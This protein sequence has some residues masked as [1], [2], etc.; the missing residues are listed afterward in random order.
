MSGVEAEPRVLCRDDGAVRTLSLSNPRKRNALT[1]ALLDELVRLL[2]SEAPGPRQPVRAVILQG[3]PA[4][5]AFSSGFDI[6]AIDAEEREKGLDPIR[7]AAEAIEGCPVPVI[8]AIDGA[9]FGGG[10]E[11]A[12][13]CH[14]R[15]ASSGVK[16]SMPPAKLGV[17]YSSTGLLRFLRALG[18]SQ[19]TRLFLTGEVV[20]ADEAARIGLV[21][22]R[23]DEGRA[24]E[25]ARE[26]A[27]AIAANAP[28]AVVGMLDAIR[29]LSRPGGPDADDLMAV[30]AFREQA[31]ASDDLQEGVRAFVEKRAPRFTG[32]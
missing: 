29:R 1:R 23:V 5:R 11:I 15:V 3:D 4:G 22:E 6:T 17:V 31:L 12:L 19:V 30:E 25:R 10:L 28:I 26:L 18:P 24:H 32:R 9:A 2:P 21:D 14:V 16:L 8:A 27:S 13:A 7:A 20:S